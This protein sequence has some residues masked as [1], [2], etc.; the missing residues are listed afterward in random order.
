MFGRL[1]KALRRA[2]RASWSSERAFVLATAAA[3]VGLGNIWRFPY[4]AGENGGG[5]FII[6]Y[7]IA[8]VVLGV[9]LM[10]LETTAGK[11]SLGSPVR[12]FRKMRKGGALFGWIVVGLTV[13]VMSYY[14]AITGWTLGY[15]IDS[16]TGSISSFENFTDSFASVWYFFIAAGVAFLFVLRGLRA[17]EWLAKLMMPIL[18]GIILFMAG[19]SL[20]LSGAGE[21][22]SFLF[23][24]DLSRL[25][26]PTLWLLALGQAFY[27]LAVGQGYLITYGSFVPKNTNLPRASS[28][29]AGVETSVALLAGIIIFPIIFTFGLNP[30]AGPELAFV[31]LPIAF[32]GIPIGGILATLF[33]TLLFFAAISS[34]IAGM[35][36]IKT[37][38]KEERKTTNGKAAL[39][40]FVPV[41]PLG[42]LSA[43]SF[44]PAGFEV[45][46]Q[47]FL[48]VLDLFAANQIIVA[49]GII[50]G[51]L[52]SWSIPFQELTDGLGAKRR[53][54]AGTTVSVVK[55]LPAIAGA[56]LALSWF[57]P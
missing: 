31:T 23:N 10:V 30:G 13:L 44:T 47:P 21:A 2:Q 19:Y 3:A 17:I 50:G 38:V 39:L 12:T 14:L 36:V 46:G 40:A 34:C 41:L 48:K 5:A 1:K 7:I 4:I 42:F 43:M 26:S 29:V 55:I 49:S 37:A 24:P 28:I 33:F 57:V 22:L 6:A 51:A 20:T 52:I 27:S 15:A 25:A 53:W 9:P 45:L 16:Y 18:I 8:V 11:R 56:L 32:A 54:I 35:E